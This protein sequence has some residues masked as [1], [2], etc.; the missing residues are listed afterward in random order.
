MNKSKLNDALLHL[1]NYRKGVS[2]EKSTLWCIVE[3]YLKAIGVSEKC[4]DEV[5]YKDVEA[6]FAGLF[7]EIRIRPMLKEA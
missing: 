3:N 7:D 2:E 6:D 5:I 1:Q 4:L